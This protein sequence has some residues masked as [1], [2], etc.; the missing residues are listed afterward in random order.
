MTEIPDP[1]APLAHKEIIR[2]CE[3]MLASPDF[4]VSPQQIALIRYAV[5]QALAAR[6][7][8]IRDFAAATTVFG[9]GQN[10]V[11]AANPIVSIQAARRR[12]ALAR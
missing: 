3:R 4:K 5:D 2:Q 8:E 9:R 12:Q 7:A 6:A 1:A 10:S 11:P